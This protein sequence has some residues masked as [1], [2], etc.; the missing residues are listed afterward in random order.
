MLRRLLS[1]CRREGGAGKAESNYWVAALRNS[2]NSVDPV[3]AL[4]PATAASQL[5][6]TLGSCM[7]CSGQERELAQENAKFKIRQV[8][9]HSGLC[10]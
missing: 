5:L 9:G 1:S 8:A 7:C 2:G 3:P 4:P 6:L 10:F